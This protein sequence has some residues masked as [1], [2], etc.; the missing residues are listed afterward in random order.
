MKLK[1]PNALLN[2]K[3]EVNKKAVYWI[4]GSAVAVVVIVSTLLIL[5]I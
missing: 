5:N 2:R 1:K 3:D 4:I